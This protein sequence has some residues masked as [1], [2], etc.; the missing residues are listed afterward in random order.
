MRKFWVM[1]IRKNPVIFF[2]NLWNVFQL[3]MIS[4]LRV[5]RFQKIWS[6][7]RYSRPQLSALNANRI[8]I[9]P[10]RRF[11]NPFP[12]Q[13]LKIAESIQIIMSAQNVIKDFIFSMNRSAKKWNR[14]N[15]VVNIILQVLLLAVPCV[16]KIIWFK[17]TFV[18]QEL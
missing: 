17:V 4:P 5:S 18:C 3:S 15:S 10:K 6:S 14:F 7:V 9:W 16:N 12:F 2:R 13:R 1:K 8:T 11:A